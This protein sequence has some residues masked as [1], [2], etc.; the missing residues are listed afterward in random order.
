M[1]LKQQDAEAEL[2]ELKKKRE[3]RK[4][5]VEEEEKQKKQEQEDK[6]AKEQEE[7]KKMKEEIEKRR[8]EAAEKK[9]QKEEKSSAVAFTISPKGS[10]KIGA[11]AEF[12]NK[13]AQKSTA[14]R[15]FHSPIVSKIGN[16]LEQYT[17]ALQ[18][19]LTVQYPQPW[20][21]SRGSRYQRR[22]GRTLDGKASRA[23]EDSSTCTSS[24]GRS[25]TGSSSSSSSSSSK[26][27]SKT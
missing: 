14:G 12:L 11:K 24:S 1:K 16:R 15:A 10:S 8:A 27:S 2:E 17:S 13:S 9:K 6:K 22:G 25:I 21:Y 19:R 18:V 5:V 26:A 7:R 23:G 4:K 3:D 20:W